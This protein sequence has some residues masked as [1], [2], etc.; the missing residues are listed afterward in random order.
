MAD[1]VPGVCVGWVAGVVVISETQPYQRNELSE[2]E[3]WWKV[4]LSSAEEQFQQKI[5]KDT[6]REFI[7]TTGAA[8]CDSLELATSLRQ[9]ELAN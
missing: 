8:F 5:S 6:Q 1:G 7:F 4:S 2:F 3:M 9:S